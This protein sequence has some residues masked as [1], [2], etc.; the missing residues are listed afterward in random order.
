MEAYHSLPGN[1]FQQKIVSYKS[2]P[3]QM[4]INWPVSIRYEILLK[5]IS[6]ETIEKKIVF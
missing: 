3:M 1:S 5:A 2:Q 6:E 4:E